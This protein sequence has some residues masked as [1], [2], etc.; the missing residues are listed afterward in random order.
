VFLD[1]ER[2]VTVSEKRIVGKRE[3]VCLATDGSTCAAGSQSHIT[4][5]DHRQGGVVRD[6]RLVDNSSDGVRSLSFAGDGRLLT[7]GGGGGKLTFFDTRAGAFLPAVAPDDVN[8]GVCFGS[9]W[10]THVAVGVAAEV[11]IRIGRGGRVRRLP[12]SAELPG[13]G[14]GVGLAGPRAPRVRGSLRAG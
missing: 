1:V 14:L 8:A 6:E 3:L 7:C 13:A 10:G 9:P 5:F 11:F 12:V 4:L 2:V